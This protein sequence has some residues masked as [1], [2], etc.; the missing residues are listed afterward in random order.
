M[1]KYTA[2]DG[3]LD[4]PASRF[5]LDRRLRASASLV[6][7]KNGRL[8]D[9]GCGEGHFLSRMMGL[10]PEIELFGID[11]SKRNI[12][13]VK[14]SVPT[15][16]VYVQNAEKLHFGGSY[17][18]CVSLLEVVEHFRNPSIIIM[19]SRRVLKKGG[20]LIISMPDHSRFRWR[21][22]WFLWTRSVGRRWAHFHQGKLDREG[23]VRLLEDNGFSIVLVRETLFRCIILVKARKN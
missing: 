14:K 1:R 21:L 10:C 20:E 3:V 13:Y 19:E 17:F 8:L 2:V 18:D 15:A 12:A 4:N 5:W 23:L 22:L 6:T 9:I 7:K 11:I 16:K